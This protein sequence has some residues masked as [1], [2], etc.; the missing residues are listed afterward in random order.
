MTLGKKRIRFSVTY[1]GKE[2][3]MHDLLIVVEKH[4][5]KSSSHVDFKPLEGGTY[6]HLI[7]CVI[8]SVS[9]GIVYI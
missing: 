3:K 7:L 1:A 4:H 9:D 8:K 5:F 2:L 6:Q